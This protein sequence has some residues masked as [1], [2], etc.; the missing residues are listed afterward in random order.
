M[1]NQIDDS[2]SEGETPRLVSTKY[3][4]EVLGISRT[5]LWRWLSDGRFPKP[6][7]LGPMRTV[8]QPC[9]IDDFIEKLKAVGDVDALAGTWK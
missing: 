8:W 3:V 2:T 5:T 6:M 4:C 7:Q 1:T 9:D